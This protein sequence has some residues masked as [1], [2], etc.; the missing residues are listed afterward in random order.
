MRRR[1]GTM[2]FVLVGFLT[3]ITIGWAAAPARA[4]NYAYP[5][6]GWMYGSPEFMNRIGEVL[7]AIDSPSR[8]SEVAQNWVQFAKTA[9]SKDLDFQQQWLELQREQV[10]QNQ[11]I[12]QSR[13]DMAKLQLQIEQLHAA[14]LQLEQENLQLQLELSKQG[15]APAAN[16]PTAEA[17]PGTS[18]GAAATGEPAS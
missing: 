16:P 13:V 8:R 1:L 10:Q 3:V 4:G 2:D 15:A 5:P 11:Q 14:N 6:G 12:D 9:I 18:P 7:N 17:V